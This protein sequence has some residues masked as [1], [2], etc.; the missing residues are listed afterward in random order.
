MCAETGASCAGPRQTLAGQSA[1]LEAADPSAVAVQTGSSVAAVVQ[2]AAAS[3]VDASVAS[4]G[5]SF[6]CLSVGA[7]PAEGACPECW[8]EVLLF[9]AAAAVAT[10]LAAPVAA[11]ELV[12]AAAAAVASG[13]CVESSVS[14]PGP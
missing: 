5:T 7:Q 3:A 6:D 9:V 11:V 4:S 8:G 2:P 13:A 14:G 10:G 12:A 1:Y